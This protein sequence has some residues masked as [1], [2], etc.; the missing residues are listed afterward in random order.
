MDEDSRVTFDYRGIYKDVINTVTPDDVRWTCALLARLS[1]RQWNDAFAAAGYAPE[2]AGRYVR[3][4][5]EKIAQGLALKT[6]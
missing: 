1:D 3:K 2:H 6:A 4:I 5:K